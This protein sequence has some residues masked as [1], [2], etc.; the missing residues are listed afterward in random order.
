M[1]FT[2]KDK[3]YNLRLTTKGC[4]NCEARLG[5]NPINVFMETSENK[6][7]KI[8]DLM[9]IL[10]ECLNT[11]NH[12]LKI[13]DVYALYDDYCSE[14]GDIGALIEL[15]VQVFEESGFIPKDTEGKN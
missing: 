15:L 4:V 1:L 10:H 3:Q 14:G 11:L 12:G 7:P 8:S 5:K 2:V 6:M 13:D 9:I